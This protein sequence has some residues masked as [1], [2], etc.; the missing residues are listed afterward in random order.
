MIMLLGIAERADKSARCNPLTA[1]TPNAAAP[2]GSSYF[3]SADSCCKRRCCICPQSR[4]LRHLGG[5]VLELRRCPGPPTRPSTRTRPR[6]Q[7]PRQRKACWSRPRVFSPPFSSCPSA[8]RG[9]RPSARR[10]N[11][12][13]KVLAQSPS[14]FFSGSRLAG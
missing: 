11:P 10:K 7:A 6:H 14:A 9:R 12:R 13:R 8:G 4:T 3:D 1:L 2:P 5:L